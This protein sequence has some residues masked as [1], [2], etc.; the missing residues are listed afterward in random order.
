MAVGMEGGRAAWSAV[1]GPCRATGLLGPGTL[2]PQCPL[3]EPPV[4]GPATSSGPEM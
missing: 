1:L 3:E 2:L 4:A